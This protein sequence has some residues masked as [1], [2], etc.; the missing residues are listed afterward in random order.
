ML[1]KKGTYPS[2]RIIKIRKSKQDIKGT[3]K[4]SIIE[5]KVQYDGYES[6]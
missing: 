3:N 6:T 5:K 4:L 1:L 2:G